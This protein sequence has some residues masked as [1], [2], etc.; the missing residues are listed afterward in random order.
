[1]LAQHFFRHSCLQKRALLRIH[2]W[3]QHS[4]AVEPTGVL[5]ETRSKGTFAVSDVR[6]R[7]R[8]LVHRHWRRCY[9]SFRVVVHL[10]VAMIL[11]LSSS[12]G[13]VPL[14]WSGLHMRSPQI[15]RCV[16]GSG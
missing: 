12:F 13:T 7:E 4:E 2:C 9:L 3:S 6:R 11:V 8:L 16:Q 5:P 10:Y 14:P 1:M 15:P